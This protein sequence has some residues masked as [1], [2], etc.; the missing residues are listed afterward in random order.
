MYISGLTLR[1]YSSQKDAFSARAYSAD[2]IS[3]GEVYTCF[4]PRNTGTRSLRIAYLS[5]VV[6]FQRMVGC[7]SVRGA[8]VSNFARLVMSDPDKYDGIKFVTNYKGTNSSE[9][10]SLS[11]STMFIRGAGDKIIGMLCINSRLEFLM[12]IQSMLDTIIKHRTRINIG[13]DTFRGDILVDVSKIVSDGMSHLSGDPAQLTPEA[14]KALVGNLSDRGIFL[15]RGAV[16]EV[17]K[18]LD[19]SEQTV[20]RYMKESQT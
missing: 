19:V 8:D 7:V 6:L 18:R 20:Y 11:T 9:Y 16:S 17:A 3:P 5:R 2:C 12:R 1:I 14:K 4:P 13:N 10:N 15:V